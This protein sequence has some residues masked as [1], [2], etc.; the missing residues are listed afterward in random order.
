LVRS[1][2]AP[3]LGLPSMGGRGN[4]APAAPPPGAK[5]PP[6][7]IASLI[8]DVFTV[9][10]VADSA[11]LARVVSE[12][13]EQLDGTPVAQ[14]VARF[15]QMHER[16]GT[17]TPTAMWLDDDGAVTVAATTANEG[18]A[19]FVFSMTAGTP[20]KIRSMRVMVGG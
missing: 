18:A 3:L 15:R 17:L 20:A 19:T 13:F 10:N 12:R 5:V 11:A 8:R 7:A 16:L 2:I 9:V 6:P 14:R 4:D 1:A